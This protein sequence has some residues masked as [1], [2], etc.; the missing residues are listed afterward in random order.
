MATNKIDDGSISTLKLAK[1]QQKYEAD[2][3]NTIIRHALSASTVNQVAKSLDRMNEVD[4]SFSLDIKTMPVTN[5]K[6]SGRCWIF[7]ACNVLREI[8]AKKCNMS[9]F[10]ISQ[11]QIAF[12]DKLEKINFEME[13]IIDLLGCE[14]DDRSLSCVMNNTIGDGGQ[15]DMFVNIVKKYGIVPKN[16]KVETAT[17]S[18]TGGMNHL[19]TVELRKFA[20]KANKLYKE[21][22]IVAVRKA[23]DTLFNKFYNLLVS[24]YG[25]PVKEFD[26]EYVDKDNKY[27]LEKGFT[28][29]TFFEKYIGKEIDDYVS[30]INAPTSDK[31]FG[32]TYTVQYLGNVWGGKVVTH[33][34]LPMKRVKELILKQLKDDQIVW[35]GSDVGFYRDRDSYKWDD[36][37]YDYDSLFDLDFYCDKGDALDYG[38]SA[39]NHAMCI[40]GVN[41][42]KGIPTKWK[43][44]NSWGE[45]QAKKGYYL[46]SNTWFDQYVYQ[47]VINKK[48]LSSTE[49]QALKKKPIVL[50]P[51][52]PMGSLAD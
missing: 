46:M 28:P 34:N 36:K 29:L 4:Y 32:V 2:A 49:L 24:C 40:T 50:K 6:A 11:N 26:F 20:A 14:Y 44:E 23:K 48:Y 19:I 52:D 15:W 17:S 45:E 30:I 8:I 41:L 5:Q 13:A 10:E 51:W 9:N 37:S 35:F 43:I 22:G 31:K 47:A 1:L 7:A 42:V 33:L 18:Q 27:H 25:I 38:V 21:K 12:Y 39:M 16:V 3:K